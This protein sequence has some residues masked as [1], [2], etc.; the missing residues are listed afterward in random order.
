MLLQDAES[1][2]QTFPNEGPTFI[3]EMDFTPNMVIHG[4]YRVT[5]TTIPKEGRKGVSSWGK[6]AL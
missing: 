3:P 6:L 2:V 4:L 1:L 5:P